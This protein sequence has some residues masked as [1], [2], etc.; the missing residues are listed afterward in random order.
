MVYIEASTHT[1]LKRRH[2]ESSLLA[3]LRALQL[4]PILP[5]VNAP[6]LTQ[7]AEFRVPSLLDNVPGIIDAMASGSWGRDYE[8]EPCGLCHGAG[9]LLYEAAGVKMQ[10]WECKGSRVILRQRVSIA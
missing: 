10:C 3:R 9:A 7:H 2:T 4:K 8:V 1:T 5:T 6:I